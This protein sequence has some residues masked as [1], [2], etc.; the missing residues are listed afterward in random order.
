[1]NLLQAYLQNPRT[2]RALSRKPSEKGFSLIELVVVIAV[3]AVL[4][5]IALPNFLGVS[6]DASARAAQQAA[7]TAFKECQ[8]AAARG[9]RNENSVF[10][11]P[12]VQNWLIASLENGTDYPD[13]G[14]G[15][16]DAA[17]VVE[18][19]TQEDIT[20]NFGDDFVEGD[21]A[22]ACFNDEGA[23][24]E[25]YAVPVT[26]D[27]FPTYKITTTGIKWCVTGTAEDGP[28]TYNIGCNTQEDNET[29]LNAD[30]DEVSGWL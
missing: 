15:L 13:T 12:S 5:A 17:G 23:A 1:M 10:Q 4:T 7:I 8:V 22:S 2:Q 3:L 11:S 28:G 29:P 21:P 19:V 30:D 14:A 24:R 16:L 26:T 9:Q 25:I 18:D 27:Q 6:D 20:G